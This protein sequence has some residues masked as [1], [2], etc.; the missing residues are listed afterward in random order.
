L[1][2]AG[3]WNRRR[4]VMRYQSYVPPGL[5]ERTR[6]IRIAFVAG[7]GIGLLLGWFFHGI[8]SFFV[9]FGL[10]AL[11]LLPLLIIGYL[12]WRSSRRPRTGSGPM[13]VM[14]WSNEFP[15]RPPGAR[16][17][18]SRMC[19][20]PRVNGGRRRRLPPMTSTPNWTR[21]GQSGSGPNVTVAGDGDRRAEGPH[22]VVAD[23]RMTRPVQLQGK[24][25]GAVRSSLTASVPGATSAS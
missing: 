22:A 8:I 15:G 24:C 14:T 3:D 11:L 4:R 23:A 16:P 21:S 5:W 25:T 7:L 10:V 20:S 2:T 13:T 9:Q 17:G 12:W 6:W 1:S 19:R 18:T